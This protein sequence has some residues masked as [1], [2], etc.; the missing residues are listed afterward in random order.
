L[1]LDL[2]W[3]SLAGALL[4][5]DTNLI[6]MVFVSQPLISC[7]ITGW[8]L[9]DTLSGM[10]FGFLMQMLWLGNMPFGGSSVP[11]GNLAS[12]TGTMI[13]ISLMTLFPGMQHSLIILTFFYVVL[14]SG[15]GSKLVIRIRVKSDVLLD[16]AIK[17]ATSSDLSIVARISHLSLILNYA[18]F[19]LFLFLASVM[20]ALAIQ[21]ILLQS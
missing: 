21:H 15:L 6:L 3:A 12:M 18:I 10:H 9:G 8:L 7:T 1:S 2:L 17:K 14:V 20:G 13:Y 5:L 16:W 11:A 4:A 19:V